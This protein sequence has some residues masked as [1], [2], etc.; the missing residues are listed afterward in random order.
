MA[1]FRISQLASHLIVRQLL[2]LVGT[3]EAVHAEKVDVPLVWIL[4]QLPDLE[5]ELSTGALDAGDDGVAGGVGRSLTTIEQLLGIV[6][7]AGKFFDLVFEQRRDN[8]RRDEVQ[9]NGESQKTRQGWRETHVRRSVKD[10]MLP[11]SERGAGKELGLDA[12]GDVQAWSGGRSGGRRD[13]QA[14][15]VA[16]ARMKLRGEMESD[17]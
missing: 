14:R 6:L 12:E 10:R 9:E 17:V 1:A 13:T 2:A 15:K 7:I 5:P 16:G 8:S 4:L 11:E 3:Q